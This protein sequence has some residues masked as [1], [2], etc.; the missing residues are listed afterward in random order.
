MQMNLI[1]KS[2]S[3]AVIALVVAA[4][5][6][7]CLLD[8][9][10]CVWGSGQCWP[11]RW[12]H[13]ALFYSGIVF[14]AL[15]VAARWRPLAATLLVVLIQFLLMVYFSLT[16]IWAFAYWV[17]PELLVQLLLATALWL[18]SRAARVPCE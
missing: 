18:A 13:N 9:I 12:D 1:G 7:R 15:A 5:I 14:L 11:D 6:L 4:A 16:V 2:N 3:K 10:R 8:W 17:L